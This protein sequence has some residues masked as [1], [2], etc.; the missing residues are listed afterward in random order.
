MDTQT[1]APQVE[2]ITT[3]NGMPVPKGT[4]QAYAIYK[5][6][7][8]DAFSILKGNRDII[9]PHVDR[10]EDSMEQDGMLV[11]P[12]CVN[13]KLQI[14]DGQHTI[15]AAKRTKGYVYF[16]IVPG[17]GL[18][19]VHVFNINQANW[20][21][22]SYM[23]S[24]ASKGR[25]DYVILK[26][27]FERHRCFNLE[28]CVAMCSNI[29]TGRNFRTR[30]RRGKDKAERP[31]QDFNR[32]TWKSRNMEIAELWANSLK[33]L[34]PYFSDGYSDTG[35]VGAMLGIFMDIEKFD[36]GRFLKKAKYQQRKFQK[37]SNRKQY[38]DLIHEIY[39]FKVREDNWLELRIRR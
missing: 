20:T 29:S 37:E 1:L 16:Y 11:N 38:R 31:G 10:L 14:I 36:F 21:M 28:D 27:F 6:Y 17:Y 12:I 24:H 33:S 18:K 19:E 3:V 26:E 13:E 25:K 9:W 32:G 39:N 15:E 34:K 4:V 22:K 30:A 2:G 8:L 23:E 5:T 7:D 35:F